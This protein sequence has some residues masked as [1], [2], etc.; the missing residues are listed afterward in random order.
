MIFDDFARKGE[1][2]EANVRNVKVFSIDIL[3]WREQEFPELDVN[4]VCG[5][6]T[7]IRA[8]ARDLGALLETGRTLAA[9]Q[10]TASSGFTQLETKLAATEF[11]PM[12]ADVPLQHFS[13]IILAA[14]EARR[15]CQGQKIP[16]DKQVSEISRVYDEERRFL[17]IGELKEELLIPRMVLEGVS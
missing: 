15:W 16:V 3:D 13:E 1:K 4:I 11:Q 9:L 10:P 5:G 8:L 2:I 14:T 6:G 7:Y 17:G 12:A